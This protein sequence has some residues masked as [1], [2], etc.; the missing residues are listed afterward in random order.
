MSEAWR[1]APCVA[2]DSVPGAWNGGPCLFRTA[3][4]GL[5]KFI[6]S[7]RNACGNTGTGLCATSVAR[8]SVPGLRYGV[9][10]GFPTD[11][12]SR[13]A[14][15]RARCAQFVAGSLALISLWTEAALLPIDASQ[16]W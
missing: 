7:M 4:S 1:G 10:Q 3:H 8:S 9:R 14:V 16:G 6:C 5:S 13:I 11:V 15:A 12:A 2:L